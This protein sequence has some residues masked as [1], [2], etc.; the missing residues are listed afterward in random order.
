VSFFGK[1]KWTIGDEV[2]SCACHLLNK[3]ATIS[4]YSSSEKLESHNVT[5]LGAI[6]NCQN[7]SKLGIFFNSSGIPVGINLPEP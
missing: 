6:Y 7:D 2:I 3:N 1:K 4:T 5:R